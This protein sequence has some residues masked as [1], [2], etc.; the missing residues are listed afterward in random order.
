VPETAFRSYTQRSQCPSDSDAA[1]AV[2]V[3][4][5]YFSCNVLHRRASSGDELTEGRLTNTY[6]LLAREIQ[7]DDDLVLEDEQEVVEESQ[8]QQSAGGYSNAGIDMAAKDLPPLPAEETDDLSR[9][10]PKSLRNGREGVLPAHLA[11]RSP[12]AKPVLRIEDSFEELDKLE[13]EFEAVDHI[14][15]VERV[16]SPDKAPVSAQRA[17][18]TLTRGPVT[19]KAA[20]LRAKA[21]EAARSGTVYKPTP[22]TR[23]PVK[24]AE[25]KT[26]AA[27]VAP[28]RAP[29][30]RPTSLAPPKAL[31]K[32]EKIP[33]RPTFELPGE[34]IARK[35]KEKKEA[36][37]SLMGTE[38]A[39]AFSPPKVKSN[40]VPTRPTFEL[41][42]EAI[43]RRKREEH[44]AKLKAQADEE[45]RR[46]E[47]KARPVR[48]SIA[49]GSY[50]R[51]TLS[52][53]ARQTKSA[54]EESASALGRR[55]SLLPSSRAAS[56]QR[57]R[58]ATVDSLSTNGLGSRAASSSTG[59]ISGSKRSTVS[60]EDV[61]Q[62]RLRGREIYSRDNSGLST[63]RD[64]QR[65]DREESAKAARAEAA[66]RSRQLSR[67]WAEK[68]KQRMKKTMPV[69][70]PG[71]PAGDVAVR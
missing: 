57:G 55:Q 19:T 56:S 32:S 60:A 25:E 70:N 11:P 2:E 5:R 39:P 27:K 68:Q 9:V 52:S 40:K 13:D 35:L 29:V 17:R 37:M 49:P 20:M 69:G 31:A 24:A 34:A 61:Q 41:P 3:R 67:E 16:P 42:G 64:Q 8:P 23:P 1:D 59:S 58:G 21:A 10:S 4:K 6:T 7:D 44:E 50:P 65:R 22:T 15:Q 33:T 46:R 66:E 18:A 36:R 28:Q 14:V 30:P 53:R 54:S 45:K 71:S 38:V 26:S 63:N 48:N 51:E 47:F 62:Q 43:S 12:P